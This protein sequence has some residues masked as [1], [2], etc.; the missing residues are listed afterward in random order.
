M[1]YTEENCPWERNPKTVEAM[2]KSCDQQTRWEALYQR[3]APYQWCIVL[4][5]A[6]TQELCAR[7]IRLEAREN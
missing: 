2:L 3:P 6:F 7:I 5:V 1:E 4:A